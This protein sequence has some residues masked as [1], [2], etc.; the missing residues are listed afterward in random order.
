MANISLLEVLGPGQ[1]IVGTSASVAADVPAGA[2]YV[3]IVAEGGLAYYQFG[4]GIASVLSAGC[5][6]QNTRVVEGPLRDLGKNGMVVF[7]TGS[8]TM[9][10]Q[11]YRRSRGH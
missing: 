4:S 10:I 8:V 2:E 3:Q 9:H 5:V 1:S 11:Y 6:P 7:A